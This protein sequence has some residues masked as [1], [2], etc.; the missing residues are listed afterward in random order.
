MG[1]KR[2]DNIVHSQ[3]TM[4]LGHIR[5]DRFYKKYGASFSGWIVSSDLD[6]DHYSDPISNRTDAIATMYSMYDGTY[7]DYIASIS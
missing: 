7:E 3:N 1:I 2:A 5:A 6:K 4:F